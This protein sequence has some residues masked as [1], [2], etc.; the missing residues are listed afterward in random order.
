MKKYLI[1]ATTF[2]LLFMC[3]CNGI[4]EEKHPDMLKSHIVV[5]FKQTYPSFST[6]KFYDYKDSCYV[7]YKIP[8]YYSDKLELGDTVKS[9]H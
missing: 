6:I 8:L 3:S 4:Y 7:I 1:L 2:L 9:K 5:G